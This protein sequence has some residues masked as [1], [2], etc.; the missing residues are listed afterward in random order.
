[1]S[2]MPTY[3]CTFAFLNTHRPYHICTSVC[4]HIYKVQNVVYACHIY[5]MCAHTPPPHTPL[6]VCLSIYLSIFLKHLYYKHN[7]LPYP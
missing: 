3:K 2:V 5:Y 7:F 6:S 1:M 4:K